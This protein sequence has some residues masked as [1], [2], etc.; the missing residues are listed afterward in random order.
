M[1]PQ[2]LCLRSYSYCGWGERVRNERD[3][4]HHGC[5]LEDAVGSLVG[6]CHCG[7]VSSSSVF[8]R[9]HGQHLQLRVIWGH[10][11]SNGLLFYHLHSYCIFHHLLVSLRV[12]KEE[13]NEKQ[14]VSVMF[15][16]GSS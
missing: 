15:L 2:S 6:T 1:Q 3:A 4:E 8:L 12:M 5:L 7:F 14:Y 11:Y 16:G 9:H 13:F 10:F